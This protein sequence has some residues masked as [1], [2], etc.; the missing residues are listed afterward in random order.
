MVLWNAGGS[1]PG[2]ISGTWRQLAEILGETPISAVLDSYIGHISVI[3]K[4][5]NNITWLCEITSTSQSQDYLA[6]L[7]LYMASSKS[8]PTHPLE[9]ALGYDRSSRNNPWCR[10]HAFS[11]LRG[12]HPDRKIVIRWMPFTYRQQALSKV[13]L[14][15]TRKDSNWDLRLAALELLAAWGIQEARTFVEEDE[16]KDLPVEYYQRGRI[17]RCSLEGEEGYHEWV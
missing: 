13:I 4:G 9:I 17:L 15:Y 10:K 7:V 2:Y 14:E 1:L 11:A 6:G 3:V 8:D 12:L 5:L 16:I